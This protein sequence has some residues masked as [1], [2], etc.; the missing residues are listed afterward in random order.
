MM[1]GLYISY[2]KKNYLVLHSLNQFLKKYSPFSFK[3]N[4]K[5]SVKKE[6]METVCVCGSAVVLLPFIL[7]FFN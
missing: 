3:K 2:E 1:M 6:Q 7:Y 5:K 4:N